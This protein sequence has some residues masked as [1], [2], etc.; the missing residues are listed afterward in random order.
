MASQSVHDAAKA[1]AKALDG[2]DSA[3]Q[4]ARQIA[5]YVVES[6]TVKDIPVLIC[7]VEAIRRRRG[8][9]EAVLSSARPVESGQR[10]QIERII[11]T[12]V[13][14]ATRIIMVERLDP[15]LVGGVRVHVAGKE[16]DVTVRE[17]LNRLKHI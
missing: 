16:F 2:P 7:Q 10:S 6:R 8:I 12:H 14:N 1:I 3:G 15:S 11:R 13:P 17:K 5:A 9:V 4:T